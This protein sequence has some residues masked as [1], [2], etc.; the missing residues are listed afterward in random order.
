MKIELTCSYC[1]SVLRVDAIHAGKQLSC[2]TCQNLIPIP[3][4]SLE[5]PKFQSY[6]PPRP[7]GGYP[8][9]ESRDDRHSSDSTSL[10]IGILGMIFSFTCFCLFP[11]WIL[12]N[13]YGMY[14]A[15]QMQG[16]GR[17][18]AIITNG[19]ALAMESFWVLSY[20]GS[21]F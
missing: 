21:L 5:E 10:A 12:M 18:A 6:G 7:E 1:E 20:I 4:E 17:K 15:F 9:Y 19:I 14:L 16:R 13:S 2:P 3:A 11:V 8:Q